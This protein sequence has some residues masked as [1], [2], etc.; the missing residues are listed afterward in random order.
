MTPDHPRNL[1]C[2]R[3]ATPRC[4]AALFSTLTASEIAAAL[5]NAVQV[6]YAYALAPE[7]LA[8]EPPEGAGPLLDGCGEG[9]RGLPPLAALPAGCIQAGGR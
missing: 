3:I 4:A 6:G 2:T 7:D 1:S 8:K 9:K 5:L